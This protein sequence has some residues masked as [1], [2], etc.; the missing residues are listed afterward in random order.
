[1]R[2]NRMTLAGG[3]QDEHSSNGNGNGASQKQR[4]YIVTLV[5]QIDWSELGESERD[6][7]LKSAAADNLTKA[8]ASTIIDLLKGLRK[9][10]SAKFPKH[11]DR[12]KAPAQRES[13]Q[14]SPPSPITTPGVFET[15]EGIFI[16]K[17]TRDK[18]RLYAKQLVESP[19]RL[20]ANGEGVDFDFVY[21]KGA[22]HR[23]TEADRMDAERAKALTIRY[24]RCIVCGRRLKAK[25]SVE[26]GIGPVCIKYF[27]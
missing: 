9:E 7:T 16:V 24:G 27:A 20:N 22:I 3:S 4:D 12:V 15:D 25:A 18:Q 11:G 5:G 26:R 1:M 13:E 23:L 2:T 14:S 21:A 8:L 17:P 19:P 6:S 10:H